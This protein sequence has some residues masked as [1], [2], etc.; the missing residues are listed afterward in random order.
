MPE[1]SGGIIKETVFKFDVDLANLKKSSQELIDTQQKFQSELAQTEKELITVKKRIA[2]IY[3]AGYGVQKEKDIPILA[4]LA[5]QEVD[6]KRKIKSIQLQLEYLVDVENIIQEASLKTA[7][8]SKK[9]ADET[10]KSLERVANASKTT[11]ARVES[12]NKALQAVLDTTLTQ[13]SIK[14][15][16][17]G[18]QIKT[19]M[20]EATQ[21]LNTFIMPK[22]A[23]SIGGEAVG[24][25]TGS[26]FG[27]IGGVSATGGQLIADNVIEQYER[28]LTSLGRGTPIL[29]KET[30]TIRAYRIAWT[31]LADVVVRVKKVLGEPL[32]S[33]LRPVTGLEI[34]SGAEIDS[35]R[36]KVVEL[37]EQQYR[38]I[39]TYEKGGEL[40]TV[41]MKAMD[42]AATSVR[43]LRGEI[44]AE[45]QTLGSLKAV[46][47]N[48]IKSKK[49]YKDTILDLNIAMAEG[50]RITT[51][52]TQEEI[53]QADAMLKLYANKKKWISLSEQE[54][55]VINAQINAWI[56]GTEVITNNA[57]MLDAAEK[58]ERQIAGAIEQTTT[59]IRNKAQA[60]DQIIEAD[61]KVIESTEK[62]AASQNI[63][64][65]ELQQTQ[66]EFRETAATAKEAAGAMFGA[67]AGGLAIIPPT[68]GRRG[69]GGGFGADDMGGG[70]RT[71]PAMEFR[72][73]IALAMEQLQ[74]LTNVRDYPGLIALQKELDV[75][76]QRLISLADESRRGMVTIQT[77][78]DTAEE[79]VMTAKEFTGLWGG[80]N[81]VALELE[82]AEKAYR[83]FGEMRP[84]T[85]AQTFFNELDRALK[86]MEAQFKR[87]EITAKELYQRINIVGEAIGATGKKSDIFASAISR[88]FKA[89]QSEKAVEFRKILSQ[90]N[91]EL[92]KGGNA[93][94]AI[95]NLEKL[96]KQYSD[97]SMAVERLEKIIVRLQSV[98]GKDLL[99]AFNESLREN[100]LLVKEGAQ[101]LKQYLVELERALA[102][103][104]TSTKS[105]PA[106][107]PR[108]RAEIVAV[109]NEIKTAEWKEFTFE[110]TKIQQE[111][112]EA[113]GAI[114]PFIQRLQ[115]LK[116]EWAGNEQAALKID[117]V[118][119]Q[120][121]TSFAKN[122]FGAFKEQLAGIKA[123]FQ[124][125]EISA[126]EW[127]E[128]LQ[129][130]LATVGTSGPAF[131]ELARGIQAARTAADSAAMREYN[132]SIQQLTAQA[133]AGAITQRQLVV[134]LEA[135]RPQVEGN[136]AAMQKLEMAIAKARRGAG[137]MGVV[138]G[139]LG[140]IFKTAQHHAMWM[141]SGAL[142]M[143]LYNLPHQLIST[144][145][146]LDSGFAK[147]KTVLQLD[148]DV[149]KIP[150][151]LDKQF[152]ELKQSTFA[153]AKL[154][155]E[156]IPKVINMQFLMAQKYKKSADIITVSNATM[157]LSILDYNKDVEKTASNLISIISQLKIAPSE[158]NDVVNKIVLAGNAVKANAGEILEAWIR[159]ASA[160]TSIGAD[161]DTQ[162]M[163]IASSLEQTGRTAEVVGTS[164]RYIAIRMA[165]GTQKVADMLKGYGVNIH[166]ALQ[167][168]EDFN[169]TLDDMASVYL[170]MSD[171]KRVQ[172]LTEVSGMRQI[173]T[174][175]PLIDEIVSRTNGLDKT[176]ERVKNSYMK[177]TE[178]QR[179]EAVNEAMLTELNT[180]D[181]RFKSVSAMFKELIDKWGASEVA[182][183]ATLQFILMIV[184]LI[185]FL[186]ENW[187]TI[188]FVTKTIGLLTIA[189][190]IGNL[191]AFK[192]A[193]TILGLNK[194]LPLMG[195]YSITAGKKLLTLAGVMLTAASRMFWL[196]AA[197]EALNIVMLAMGSENKKK[198]A[199][200]DVAELHLEAEQKGKRGKTISETLKYAGAGLKGG[201]LPDVNK[202]AIRI[203]NEA[204]KKA[205][206]RLTEEYYTKWEKEGLKEKDKSKYQ[207]QLA[208]KWGKQGFKLTQD[209]LKIIKNDEI[210]KENEALMKGV[211]KD[212]QEI[213]DEMKKLATKDIGD[214]GKQDASIFDT[215][216]AEGKLKDAMKASS[217]VVETYK[218][219]LDSLKG[220]VDEITKSHDALTKS[221]EKQK[222]ELFS[223]FGVLESQTP[224][225]ETL[226]RFQTRFN[227]L[228]GTQGDYLDNTLSTI[229]AL[230]GE[231]SNVV[232]LQNQATASSGEFHKNTD[233]AI[234]SIGDVNSSLAGQA[235]DLFPLYQKYAEMYSVPLNLL[236]AV[237][238]A[239]SRFN[240]RATSPKGAMGLMQLMPGTARDLGVTKPY[241]PAQNIMGG[242]KYLRQVYDQYPQYG[243]EGALGSYNAGPKRTKQFGLN[244]PYKETRDYKARIKGYMGGGG[245][246]FKEIDTRKIDEIEDSYR[247]LQENSVQSIS[248]IMRKTEELTDTAELVQKQI[249]E[250]VSQ[251]SQAANSVYEKY[252]SRQKEYNDWLLSSQQISTQTWAK[253][254]V[255]IYDEANAA[256]RAMG[257]NTEQVMKSIRKDPMKFFK[258]ISSTVNSYIE[259]AKD[260]REK[261]IKSTSEADRKAYEDSAK[262]LDA[263]VVYWEIQYQQGIRQL[264]I[265]KQLF[266][267][268]KNELDTNIQINNLRKEKADFESNME[269]K[270]L[271]LL[272]EVNKEYMKTGELIEFNNA[273]LKIAEDMH[274]SLMVSTS[275]QIGLLRLKNLLY[276]KDEK[277][278]LEIENEIN[279]LIA[280][281]VDSETQIAEM[282][283]SNR[284]SEYES[285]LRELELRQQFLDN[286][287]ELR[288]FYASTND[289]R[290]LDEE[291]INRQITLAQ[292][293]IQSIFDFRKSRGLR[294]DVDSMMRV[295]AFVE[296]T[297]NVMQ[298]RLELL[299]LNP[300]FEAISSIAKTA[301][302][303]MRN[304]FKENIKAIIHGEKSILEGARDI[305][306]SRLDII[307]KTVSES[308]AEAFAQSL[309][310]S[311]DDFEKQMRDISE[312]IF[313]MFGLEAPNNMTADEIFKDVYD[314]SSHAFRVTDS[315]A[316]DALDKLGGGLFQF[317]RGGSNLG[318]MFGMMEPGGYTGRGAGGGLGGFLDFGKSV[319]SGDIFKYAKKGKVAP[320]Q[321]KAAYDTM[322]IILADM[323]AQGLGGNAGL[324]TQLGGMLGYSM[325]AAAGAGS[326][327]GGLGAAAGPVGMIAGALV[328]KT[329][330]NILGVGR[331]EERRQAMAS[332][333]QSRADQMAGI[334]ERFGALGFDEDYVTKMSSMIPDFVEMSKRSKFGLSG[335]SRWLEGGEAIYA[336]IG[337]QKAMLDAMEKTVK[338]YN[339]AVSESNHQLAMGV[340]R[341]DVF[342]KQF[343]SWVVDLEGG[344]VAL[345]VQGQT[346]DAYTSNLVSLS[347]AGGALLSPFI[348][349]NN[350]FNTL[351]DRISMMTYWLNQMDA[352]GLASTDTFRQLQEQLY[353]L[354]Q[355]KYW[356]DI[357]Q[358]IKEGEWLQ[359]FGVKTDQDL[360]DYYKKAVGQAFGY[361]GE[362]T[363]DVMK[364]L[365]QQLAPEV[366]L[367]GTGQIEGFQAQDT[368]NRM[369][370]LQA[371]YN[372]TNQI[373]DNNLAQAA[374]GQRSVGEAI[375]GTAQV[376]QNDI[377][378]EVNAENYFSTKTEMLNIAH[379]FVTMIKQQGW[380]DPAVFNI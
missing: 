24:G 159:N 296:A 115:A 180:L 343:N 166:N 131:N 218:E 283:K 19:S 157:R 345:R 25:L 97:N 108:L 79:Y 329:L 321:A 363:L 275:I 313:N 113:P 95:A 23:P 357:F 192:F 71:N 117:K 367:L 360:M 289:Q 51:T 96:K 282:R 301:M 377:K 178:A 322:G 85:E 173:Q 161:L 139:G 13:T 271:H 8:T 1:G 222:Q 147:L 340:G 221:L 333:R 64:Q 105:M 212:S 76:R 295:P 15:Q 70:G 224:G 267:N 268:R 245:D 127:L 246:V 18:A 4:G 34:G 248:E 341:F 73:E 252:T 239:E 72:N 316:T 353:E 140:K 370:L 193:G 35:Y 286:E 175:K 49:I 371:L 311:L 54:V 228:L 266:E 332:E 42:G 134:G 369:D 55:S 81:K 201:V 80:I 232:N 205:Y 88:A 2:E 272:Y 104:E 50:G 52:L 298:L 69:G 300:V 33:G 146:E 274:K 339:D 251:Y 27:D 174:I 293:K 163:L 336:E 276:G 214:L 65:S 338:N 356:A 112:R 335:T 26:L 39:A 362:I 318:K 348:N 326:L 92:L 169:K 261:A 20:L 38:Q 188:K 324:G 292:E 233:K 103:W 264:A 106:F 344:R 153:F 45:E 351:T 211:F 195:D 378:F 199:A 151:Q 160:F 227:E 43:V 303:D 31:E 249:L 302:D 269:L 58:N 379:E 368:Q 184:R 226:G 235:G 138:V 150:G 247:Q 190:K 9:G 116:A 118:I 243:W 337:R 257:V 82:R 149:N 277:T 202:E 100:K 196:V 328:G 225:L 319:F 183:K 185:K 75:L 145:K 128:Q 278:R 197:A 94:A 126:R 207:K 258:S 281:Q 219:R 350:Q 28:F 30:D 259:M 223:L 84:G 37:T 172:F 297:K 189:F 57:R 111:F 229:T 44:S 255:D 380:I 323:V 148:P 162:L 17:M 213:I 61:Y 164:W 165:G 48:E 280:S 99:A 279:N 250:L 60:E 231:L 346:F 171:K 56:N 91:I 90:I 77:A 309:T 109:K 83:G 191:E 361:Q 244:I 119:N 238:K 16:K 143:P 349:M 216:E 325:G 68:G 204:V 342:G 299:K 87:G 254:Q 66:N 3:T 374:V 135:L 304:S 315:K 155:G 375:S 265:E 354:Q 6:I 230:K 141:L 366:G 102:Q 305:L 288:K 241:D 330:D 208:E 121:Q 359:Q 156:E 110:L 142:I 170:K 290:L 317:V 314:K 59:A 40:I 62:Q 273:K 256:M 284:D 5:S 358:P 372:L 352:V 132:A 182:K 179:E 101:S 152:K 198:M 210:L 154:Y 355:K 74:R 347:G 187:K 291:K 11:V 53:R 177:M 262:W 215:T 242:A 209:E 270:R 21:A 263:Q 125:G 373:S 14:Y 67:G 306:E 253:N 203:R 176:M 29:I 294:T 46:T 287:F 260:L 124:S 114:E 158:I 312:G 41:F 234:S 36:Q 334:S 63:L 10:V 307:K 376:I 144:I 310:G 89:M 123:Q 12:D 220:S 47:D 236:L 206:D 120:L 320:K 365:A 122:N 133:A 285:T 129:A 331:G 136:A 93:K 137:D 186:E 98:A 32:P 22:M 200:Y 217:E 86:N 237:S 308:F 130:L 167:E 78:G 194:I 181:R 240:P 364:E 168:T 7:G 107:G 327:I